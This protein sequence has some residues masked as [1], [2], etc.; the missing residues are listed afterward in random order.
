MAFLPSLQTSSVLFGM[1]FFLCELSLDLKCYN[2]GFYSGYYLFF[3]TASFFIVVSRV[4]RRHVRPLFL[5]P[6]TLAPY[7]V[8]YDYL[9]VFATH[10]SVSYMMIPF[11]L[12]EFAPSVKVLASLGFCMHFIYFRVFVGITFLGGNR[13][14][15]N[16]ELACK[17]HAVGLDKKKR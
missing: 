4:V 17:K 9:G 11:L 6:S 3:A 2:L 8:V 14:L 16:V 12:K 5:E 15:R 13:L 7:K 1:V 10:F